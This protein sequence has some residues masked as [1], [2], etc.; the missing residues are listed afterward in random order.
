MKIHTVLLELDTLS[1]HDYHPVGRGWNAQ[2]AIRSR[3]GRAMGALYCD[4]AISGK[5]SDPLY[6]G[7]IAL[8]C[9]LLGSIAE[10]KQFSDCLNARTHELTRLLDISQS[11]GSTLE[12][13]PLLKQIMNALEDVLGI[14]NVSISEFINAEHDER[15]LLYQQPMRIEPEPCRSS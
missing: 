13:Q 8:Y 6:L 15:I 9:S 12:L 3:K 14:D 1:G 4:N 7:L 11:I 2:L 5:A 10:R